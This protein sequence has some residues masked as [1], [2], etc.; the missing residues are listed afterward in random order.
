MTDP[1]DRTI[2]EALD[3]EERELL[4]QIG[5]EPGYFRQIGGLFGGQLGWV[6]WLMMFWQTVLFV[7]AV[8]CA[9]QFFNAD[10]TLEALRWGMPSAVLLI[11]AGM[12]K[13]ALWPSLQ[14]NRV[15]RELKRVELQIARTNAKG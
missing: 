2:D 12:L 9:V 1:I 4:R 10:E 3:A 8:Y 15:L 7:A 6:S 5:E 11:M 13:L 14:T